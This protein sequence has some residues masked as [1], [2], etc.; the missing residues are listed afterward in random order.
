ML[1]DAKL[2]TLRPKAEPYRVA[3][4]NG[5]CIEVRPSGR[6]YWRYRYRHAGK[7][8]MVTLGEYPTMSLTD[9]RVAR[10]KA[11][12]VLESGSNPAHAAQV[13][14]IAQA[15]AAANTFEAVA[16]E[17]F[18]EHMRDNAHT[19]RARTLRILEK[20]LFPLIGKLPVGDVAAPVLLA[21]LRKIASRGVL[22]TAHRTRAL[23]GQ[24][25][26]YAI[27]TGRAERDSSSD[28][29]GALPA[30]K[31][32][33]FAA[34]VEPA[35][36]ADLLR[37]LHGYIGQPGTAAALKLAPLLFVRPGN[38][39]AMEWAEL[40]LDAAE[41]RIP[42]VKMKM[43]ERHIVPLA[44]QAIAILR[45]LQPITGR[46][47]YVFPSLRSAH[48]PMSENTVNAALRRLGFDKDTMTG[49][50]FRHMA[51]TMLHEQGFPH[52]AIER[53][54]AH[55]ERNAVSATYNW[56]QYLPQRR[57]M[58]QAWADYLDGLRTGANV[59]PIHRRK[60]A[61]E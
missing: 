41:W 8:S 54:L 13:E 28:L 17:W 58:M 35:D 11:R 1:K 10:D 59:V 47:R 16:R 9:A 50:G 49:H 30:P 53:Q 26:R 25:F 37:A 36:V 24:V 5:L 19:T 18:G 33:H 60:T 38:L 3:D 43:R 14:R 56:A 20:D 42:D 39:R 45:E 15:E 7:P 32:K 48:R 4:A 34:I 40:D 31:K 55:G 52:E 61:G 2:R 57:A 22:E 12:A 27:A 46:S 6:L 29:R 21:A 23:A 51:S 44:T